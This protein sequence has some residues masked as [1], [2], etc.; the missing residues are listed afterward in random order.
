ML[1]YKQLVLLIKMEMNVN[2]L[3]LDVEI[4]F[5]VITILQLIKN[6]NKQKVHVL[7]MELN[8]LI[9]KIV[10]KKQRV[11]AFMEVMDHVYGLMMHVI[12]IHHVNHLYLVIIHNV[13]HLVMNALLMDY[14][15]LQLI[16]VPIYLNKV[17]IKEQ[18]VDVYIHLIH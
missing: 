3:L 18:M 17:V 14:H 5:V 13:I 16:N 11:D 4:K 12:L 7:Q 8:V 2:F 10:V 1:K 15:V 9:N 6:V